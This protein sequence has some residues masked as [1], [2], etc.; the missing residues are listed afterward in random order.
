MEGILEYKGGHLPK[1]SLT[2]PTKMKN[3]IK[4]EQ[5]KQVYSAE[6][7]NF[8]QSVKKLIL[9]SEETVNALKQGKCVDGSI[10][11]TQEGLAFRAYNHQKKCGS[12][13][14]DKILYQTGCG[15]LK[16]SRQ[17]YRLWVSVPKAMGTCRAAGLMSQESNEMTNFLYVKGEE[18]EGGGVEFKR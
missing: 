12:R 16:E 4:R 11:M 18:E 17:R 6:R 14:P 10:R 13:E 15:H 8:G 1:T 2:N 9:I 3:S 7:E 5:R